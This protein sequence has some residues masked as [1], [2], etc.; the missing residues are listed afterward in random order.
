M[1]E[2]CG[3]QRTCCNGAKRI[4]QEHRNKSCGGLGAGL[5]H[6]EQVKPRRQKNSGW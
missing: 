1:M 2:W 5:A 6:T 4:K 3:R